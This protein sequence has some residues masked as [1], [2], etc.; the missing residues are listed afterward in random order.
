MSSTLAHYY[1]ETVSYAEYFI[2][3]LAH[4]YV[5]KVSH[6]I[7]HNWRLGTFVNTL[8]DKLESQWVEIL[9][10]GV[11]EELLSSH[12]QACRVCCEVYT[13]F[14]RKPKSVLV[15]FQGLSLPSY[16]PE[17]KEETCSFSGWYNY[18]NRYEPWLIGPDGPHDFANCRFCRLREME[19][20]TFSY[21]WWE[22]NMDLFSQLAENTVHSML[23]GNF[24]QQER[25]SGPRNSHLNVRSVLE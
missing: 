10:D 25:N 4:N 20:Y 12:L 8:Q 1:T 9:L 5:T 18:F 14:Q 11:G 16:E 23:K 17:V 15:F 24:V 13:C 2:G 21:F 6:N 7:P 3:K 22:E 19:Y